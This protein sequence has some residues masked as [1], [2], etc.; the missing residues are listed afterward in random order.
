MVPHVVGRRQ[1]WYMLRAK[2]ALHGT[3]LELF[4]VGCMSEGFCPGAKRVV[5]DGEGRDDG[6]SLGLTGTLRST[7]AVRGLAITRRYS[8]LHA[9]STRAMMDNNEGEHNEPKL[10]LLS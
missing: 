9:R 8:C 7:S 2:L 4:G 10:C 5:G 6:I 3:R 1:K